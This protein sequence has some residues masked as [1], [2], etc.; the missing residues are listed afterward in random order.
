MID[1]VATFIFA[2]ADTTS[3]LLTF[4]LRDVYKHPDILI[5]AR[6]EIN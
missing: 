2:G 3:N 4:A 5:A 1:E 6:K